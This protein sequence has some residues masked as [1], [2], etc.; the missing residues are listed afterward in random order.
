MIPPVL[1]LGDQIETSIRVCTQNLGSHFGFRGKRIDEKLLAKRSL[2][3]LNLLVPP[4]LFYLDKS[5]LPI[6]EQINISIFDTHSSFRSGNGSYSNSRSFFTKNNGDALETSLSILTLLKLGQST[7]TSYQAEIYSSVEWLSNFLTHTP[8][9]RKKGEV[10][11]DC[12]F[13]AYT[14]LQVA[15]FFEDRSL[16]KIAVDSLASLKFTDSVHAAH[17]SNIEISEEIVLPLSIRILIEIAHLSGHQHFF[18][19]AQKSVEDNAEEYH[20]IIQFISTGIQKR[21]KKKKYDLGACS[22]WAYNSF[23]LYGQTK[24]PDFLEIASILMRLVSDMVIMSHTNNY[25]MIPQHFNLK[26]G[27][28]SEE[29]SI[30]SIRYYLDA[31]EISKS[32]I[33]TSVQSEPKIVENN[34]VRLKGLRYEA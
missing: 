13:A 16:I 27:T 15:G 5:G 26:T 33:S 31:A 9:A 28:Y 12:I 29:G 1:L 4:F 24:N 14:I 20:D 7:S 6:S 19:L 34:I 2:Y 21:Y 3:E 10:N 8:C 23:Q 25:G 22:I 11:L 17:S 32:F 18:T 30:A